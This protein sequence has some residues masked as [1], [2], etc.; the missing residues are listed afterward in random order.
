MVSDASWRGSAG[1]IRKAD[2]LDG[3][4][5]DARRELGAWSETGFDDKGWRPAFV[6]R[7]AIGVLEGQSD[8]PVRVVLERPTVKVA[9]P[10]SGVQVFD[11]GQNIVGWARLTL[12]AP[13]GTEIQLRFAEMLNKDGTLFTDNLRSALVIDRYT[14]KGSG[15][16]TYEPRFTFHGFRYVE[17]SGAPQVLPPSAVTGLVVH[18]DL[19]VTGRFET[20]NALLNQLQSNIA[21]ASAATS[22][23]SRPIAHSATSAW[24][25]PATSRSSPAR[26]PSTWTPPPS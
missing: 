11:L 17:V 5:Y 1:P 15:P 23:R 16:E 9:S 7:P 8:P 20:S 19:P 18:S 25:G 26:R 10:T 4:I 2:L 14:A 22:S 6:V 24:A 13:A 3:E 12:S 21:W